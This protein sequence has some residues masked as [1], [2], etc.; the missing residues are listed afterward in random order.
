LGFSLG[1]TLKPREGT[2]IGIGYPLCLAEA[3]S[4]PKVQNVPPSSGPVPGEGLFSAFG[5]IVGAVVSVGAWQGKVAEVQEAVPAERRTTA[6]GISSDTV[7]FAVAF[8][9]G[10]RCGSQPREGCPC[11]QADGANALHKRLNDRPIFEEF[12][13]ANVFC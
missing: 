7:M 13:G 1:V 2:E 11:R 12:L 10:F 9:T 3:Q 8:A 6:P 4:A 5:S